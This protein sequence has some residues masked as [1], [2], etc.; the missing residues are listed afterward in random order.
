MKEVTEKEYN[1]Y[2]TTK[3]IR[4]YIYEN[5]VWK[6]VT[7]EYYNSFI[8]TKQLKY[9]IYVPQIIRNLENKSQLYKFNTGYF[10]PDGFLSDKD[11]D[12]KTIDDANLIKSRKQIAENNFS[13]K[14]AGPL[15]LKV[16]YNHVHSFG[17][18]ING[19]WDGTTATLKITGYFTYNCPDGVNT[20]NDNGD[21]DYYTF[22]TGEP[23]N[24]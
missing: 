19:T 14:L 17:Y 9:F 16:S 15:Y 21:S 18:A 13:Y 23:T 12:G 1:E 5:N 22:E 10:I 20:I 6:E 4:Y 8:G 2:K 7:K 24:I 11:I 3:E